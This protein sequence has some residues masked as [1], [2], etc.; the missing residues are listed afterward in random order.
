MVTNLLKA[1]FTLSARAKLAPNRIVLSTD[2][3]IIIKQ[4][5]NRMHSKE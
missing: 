2:I 5:N 3:A 4:N 1:S